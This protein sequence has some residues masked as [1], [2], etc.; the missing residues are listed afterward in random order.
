MGRAGSKG[1]NEEERE[2]VVGYQTR[3]H[4]C[5]ERGKREQAKGNERIWEAREGEGNTGFGDMQD[6]EREWKNDV[7]G[8]ETKEGR[9]KGFVMTGGKE[10]V[11][12]MSRGEGK[13]C[14]F[15][16]FERRGGRTSDGAK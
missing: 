2:V 4:L 9:D 5:V 14:P 6:S 10:T 16:A 15:V 1:S 8:E 11:Q 3:V 12:V 13:K 7:E